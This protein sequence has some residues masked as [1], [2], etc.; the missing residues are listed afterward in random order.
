MQLLLTEG[1]TH[2]LHSFCQP[3][4]LHPVA[5]PFS[6]QYRFQADILTLPQLVVRHLHSP[7]VAFRHQTTAESAG[8]IP[9]FC[10]KI[11]KSPPRVLFQSQ[12]IR[13]WPWK[14]KQ[15]T[16]TGVWDS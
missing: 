14:N 10:D 4:S 11:A 6:L 5:F 3:H 9:S 7:I 1:C 16:S 2:L 13:P 8:I 12:F 15:I